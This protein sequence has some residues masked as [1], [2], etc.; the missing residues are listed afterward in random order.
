MLV[1]GDELKLPFSNYSF[2]VAIARL[3]EYSPDEVCR[4]LKV[5]G[6]FFEYELGP[7]ANKEIM[8]FFSGR[9]EEENFFFPKN[10]EKW[11]NEVCEKVA[12]AGL[13]VENIEDHKEKN[14]YQSVEALMN[15][16]EMVPLVKNFDRVKDKE[17][18]GKLAEKYREK[19]GIGITWHYYILT[20]RR[21]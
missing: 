3:A 21:L 6:L 12:N 13:L 16:I 17:V 20:A 8:E 10:V 1:E 15:L 11:K 14:Y 9:I 2:D 19:Q 5:G 4:V 18:V 7:E